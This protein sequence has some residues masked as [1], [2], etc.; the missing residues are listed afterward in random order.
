[1]GGGGVLDAFALSRTRILPWG[2]FA[3]WYVRSLLIF[4]V[5]TLLSNFVNER[6]LAKAWYIGLIMPLVLILL[7]ARY[8]VNLGPLSS[9]FYFVI[10][11]AMSK[12]ILGYE[13]QN[14]RKSIIIGVCFML[15]AAVFR[16]EWFLIGYDFVNGGGTLLANA[17]VVLLFIGIWYLTDLVPSKFVDCRILQELFPLAAFVYFMH[18]PINN[19]IKHYLHIQNLDL[20]FTL[21]CVCA[22]ILYLALAWTIRK[23]LYRVYSVLSGGR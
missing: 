23:Y 1:M 22:P 5:I 3:L 11:L 19:F 14:M 18:Y 16:M 20:K 21:L 17:S 2:N 9:G 12:K 8:L 7:T 15:A 4:M 6:L 10:G 13:V